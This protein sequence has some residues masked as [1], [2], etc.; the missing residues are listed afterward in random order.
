MANSLSASFRTLWAREMQQQFWIT[1]VWRP[2]ANFRLEAEL[3]EGDTVK[4]VYRSAMVPQ[5]YTRYSDVT[6][7]D[8]T[9]TAESLVVNQ[10]PVI[11]FVI[12]DLD[13]I[14]SYPTSRE[15]YTNDS[16]E[17]MNNVINGFYLQEAKNATSVIDAADFGG[18]AGNG[19]TVTTANI[20]KIFAL[21]QKK[22]GRLNTFKPGGQN[23]HFAN[24]TPDVYQVL[25]EY[26]A[27]KESVLG[28]R[29]GE[30]GF[31]GTYFGFDLYVSN[32]MY[33]TGKIGIATQPTDGDTITI[34]V[35]PTSIVFT[36][37]TTLGSTA[38]QV[39]IGANAAAAN[40]NLAALVN[41]PGTTTSTGVALSAAAQQA[42]YGCTATAAST[43]NTFTWRGVGAPVVSSSLT[44]AADG[45]VSGSNISNL[46][47]G[48]KGA[49]DFVIQKQ[50]T[51]DVDKAENRIGEWKIKPYT[52]FGVKTFADGVKRLT[53]VKVDTTSYT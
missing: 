3:K 10:T 51:I 15:R 39:L 50:P 43:N 32:G 37:K 24:L 16:V 22:M 19:A 29:S 30:N 23:S 52:L 45:W 1:N 13:E 53:A 12:S 44:A 49:V 7:Q 47:F 9:N 2:Q 40:T 36:F 41:A 31:A 35:G 18:T 46:M 38:G 8:I 27:G 6:F 48:E 25:L 34:K 5:S 17:L 20:Q 42:L 4:R 28:D 14:Q 21:A 33:W 11:P 26:L